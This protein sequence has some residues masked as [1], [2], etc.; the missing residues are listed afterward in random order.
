MSRF[1]RVAP[2]ATTPPMTPAERR[3]LLVDA[4]RTFNSRQY[5]EAHERLEE[6][7]E[8]ADDHEF[9]L[10]LGLIQVAVGYHKLSQGLT[11]GGA[12][13]LARGVRK[14]EALAPASTELRIELLLRRA[15]ADIDAVARGVF[16]GGALA[17]DPPRLQLQRGG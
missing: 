10:L 9:A 13:M 2:P 1:R 16:N 6:G 7:L 14:L 5:F 3:R 4:A 11:G 8:T 12:Q 17:R 15:R